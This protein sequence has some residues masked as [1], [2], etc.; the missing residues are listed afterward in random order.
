MIVNRELGFDD[1]LAIARRR[2]A[3]VGLSLLL[4]TLLGFLISL[5]L[6]PKYTSRSLLLV[7][8]QLVP[9]GYVRPI[10]TERVSDRMTTLTQNVLSR[11][12]LQPVV[13]RLGLA[14]S[15]QSVDDVIEQIRDNVSVTE[16][17]PSAPPPGSDSTS[18]S[19]KSSNSSTALRKK[20]VPG[21][22]ADVPGFY[23]SFRTKSPR[24]AQQVCAE[25][26]SMLL[27]ENFK[28]RERVAESTTDFLSRQ[29]EEAKRNL[30]NLDNKLSSFEKAHLGQLPSDVD[31][32]VKMLSALSSRLDANSQS[33]DRA[34]QDLSFTQS[35]LAQ[36]E[37]VW[38]D[39]QGPPTLPPLKQ[40]LVNLQEQLVMLQARYTDDY[41]DVVKT[42]KD[43]AEIRARLKD[44]KADDASD[45]R[46]AKLEPPEILHLRRQVQQDEQ[47]IA[48]ASA[49]QRRLQK[50]S[51]LYQA[52][53]SLSP[54]IEEQY[55]QLTRDNETAHEIY[56]TLLKNKSAAE[57]QTEMER[58]QQGEQMRL[59]DPANLPGSPSFPVRWKFAA[60][61]AGA[62]LC[63]GLA[64]AMWLEFRD[65]SMRDE[66]DVLAALELP[67]LVSVPWARDD[68]DAE[69]YKKRFSLRL[70]DKKAAQV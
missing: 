46:T 61:G 30:D 6:P 49:N 47:S 66:A 39:T 13:E 21:Q 40:R 24:D 1:Y 29:L 28:L 63:I 33:L 65:K 57:M 23:I 48:Q 56:D 36:E 37:K 26:T 2:L 54:E 50:L 9:V 12:R 35:L 15:G 43:I 60:G 53:L 8:D 3:L 11:K 55:K 16:A 62:G 18:T 17:D 67:M 58:T 45:A 34:Q 44:L 68:E 32:N 69:R 4:C 22:T 64:M 51:D 42:K 25:I 20:P 5:I 41:P 38:K 52:Q 14:R 31:K 7:E 19:S 70:R 27:E 59:L 10:V